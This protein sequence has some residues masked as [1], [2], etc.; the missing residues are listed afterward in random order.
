MINRPNQ[1]WA[2]FKQPRVGSIF[3]IMTA[4]HDIIYQV[5]KLKELIPKSRLV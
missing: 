1:A 5:I 3:T 4:G 2:N